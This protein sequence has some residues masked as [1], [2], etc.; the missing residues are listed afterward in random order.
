MSEYILSCCSTAD[1]TKEHFQ[2]RNISYICFQF[3][4]DGVQYPDDLGETIP[5]PEFYQAMRDGK[6]TKTSQ[7]NV[8]EY[9]EYFESFLKEGKDVLHVCLSSG[10]SGAWNSAMIARNAV[11]ERYPDRKIYVVDSLA[12]S[13]GFGLLMDRLADLRDEGQSIDDLYRWAERNKLRVHHWVLTTDLTYFIR[14]GRI[15]KTAG[16]F[17]GML[18]ICP[19]IHVDT[20]GK[21][22][23]A[24]KVRG[25]KKGFE[26]LL[27]KMEQYAYAGKDYNG[28]CYMCQSDCYEDA[29][30]V[31]GMLEEAFPKMDGKVVINDIGTTI[32]SHTG[33]GTMAIF[34]WGDLRTE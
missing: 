24:Q 32:G 3:E 10:I 2:S 31:A 23:P 22:N 5:F 30:T 21:L 6:M 19:V 16:F 34:F 14:G 7:V 18:N 28:K 4:L 26:E 8:D 12:A 33:P 25:K 20:E 17:G 11:A 1:I 29:K 27:H 9:E 13:S 15:S